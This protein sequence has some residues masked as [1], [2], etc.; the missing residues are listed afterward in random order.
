MIPRWKLTTKVFGGRRQVLP[1][2]R[3]EIEFTATVL[4]SGS[5]PVAGAEVTF[6]AVDEGILSLT[7][8]QTPDPG[9]T[10]HAPFPLSVWTGQ[11]L[12]DLLPGNPLEQDFANK[13]YVIGGGGGGFG[14]DPDRIRKDFKALAFWE[15]ALV[16]DANGVVRAKAVAPDNLTTFRVIAVVAEG[17][18][19]GSG[20]TPVVINKPL[21]I[22][23]A[24]PDSRTSPTRSTSPR[25]STTTAARRRKWRS[26]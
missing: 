6:Y 13:G 5:K 1:A 23:P 12:G 14:L 8:Y 16:T 22:E 3:E 11:S 7:G 19:F 15:A 2:R 10:F 17:N 9:A 20:E 26:P 4:D 24:L 25:S 18:R 21:I